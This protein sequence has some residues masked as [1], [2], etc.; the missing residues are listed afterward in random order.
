LIKNEEISKLSKNLIKLNEQFSNRVKNIKRNSLENFKKIDSKNEIKNSKNEFYSKTPK[1]VENF[2]QT[3]N[4]YQKKL[5]KNEN[6]KN[7]ST[8]SINGWQ[9]SSSV[10]EL[11]ENRE[12]L[13]KLKAKFQILIVK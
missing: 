9:L 2:N 3:K 5:T 7:I 12:K 4:F 1:K 13:Q 10:S 6:S 8:K 11:R